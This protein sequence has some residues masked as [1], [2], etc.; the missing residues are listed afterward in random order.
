M[1]EPTQARTPPNGG[2]FPSAVRPQ[3]ILQP[4]LNANVANT[5]DVRRLRASTFVN[6]AKLAGTGSR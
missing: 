6:V 2:W 1:G 4:P 5:V 3:Q